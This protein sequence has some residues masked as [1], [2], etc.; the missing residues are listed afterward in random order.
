MRLQ[1]VLQGKLRFTQPTALN[2]PFELRPLF[3]IFRSSEILVGEVLKEGP[4]L[5]E[6]QLSQQLRRLTPKDRAILPAPSVVKARLFKAIKDE[7]VFGQFQTIMQP[8]MASLFAKIREQVTEQLK[9]ELGIL[10]LTEDPLGVTMW[11]HYADEHRGVALEFDA[12]HA[13]F[14]RKRSAN[15]ECLH[16]R[17]V[18]YLDLSKPGRTFLQVAEENVLVTKDSQWSN[19]REWRMLAPVDEADET[20][21]DPNGDPIYLFHLDPTAIRAVIFGV[22]ASSKFVDESRRQV[23][24]N[25]LWRHVTFRQV[26]S[27]GASAAFVLRDLE[28]AP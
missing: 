4:D 20:L 10:S 6:S 11:S 16:L 3:D 2:D 27:S 15:D 7:N 22:R 13:W 24:A 19:E 17:P 18:R 8:V 25:S 1:N 14:R 26:V 9:S 5:L 12:T 21:T 23:R 28:T